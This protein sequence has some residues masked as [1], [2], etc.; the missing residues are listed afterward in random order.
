MGPFEQRRE[1]PDIGMI[2]DKVDGIVLAVDDV[3]DAV[4]AAGLL[5]ELDQGHAGR[6]VPL[7]WLD[8]VGVA[9]S[10]A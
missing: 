7:A 2:T 5:E 10:H 3:D 8:D 1:S 4:G 6:W 9:A